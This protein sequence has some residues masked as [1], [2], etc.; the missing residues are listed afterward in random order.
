MEF[1]DRS[2]DRN[3]KYT[4][5]QEN[6]KYTIALL[7]IGG[8]VLILVISSL[9]FLLGIYWGVDP[10]LMK[11]FSGMLI[12]SLSPILSGIIFYFF[13]LNAQKTK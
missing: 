12:G 5:R 2:Q 8:F 1:Q 4:D 3:L 10:S 7:S 9:L 13:G 6:R 11:E